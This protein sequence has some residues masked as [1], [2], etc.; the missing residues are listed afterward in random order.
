VVG[1]AAAVLVPLFAQVSLICLGVCQ[2]PGGGVVNDAFGDLA[3]GGHQ[4][5]KQDEDEQETHP[6]SMLAGQAARV[7]ADRLTW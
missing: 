3:E 2:V 1:R 5:V 4:A 6:A 7:Q